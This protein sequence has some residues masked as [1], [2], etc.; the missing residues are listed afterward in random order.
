MS[1]AASRGCCIEHVDVGVDLDLKA[2]TEP[3]AN[4]TFHRRNRPAKCTGRSGH[5]QQPDAEE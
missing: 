4:K 2:V 5:R 1:A 3:P